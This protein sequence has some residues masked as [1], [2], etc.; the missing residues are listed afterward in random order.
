MVPAV[1]QLPDTATARPAGWGKSVT[2]V[3]KYLY[4]IVLYPKCL[5]IFCITSHIVSFHTNLLFL[6]D[7]INVFMQLYV[8]VFKTSSTLF[9]CK[10][11]SKIIPTYRSPLY[12]VNFIEYISITLPP[13]FAACAPGMYGPNCEAH[14]NCL[15]SAECDAA[16][17][18]C[19][20]AAGW[21]GYDCRERCLPDTYGPG[22][23]KSCLCKNNA[24]CDHVSGACLCREGWRG[25]MCERPCPE[26][27]F[28]GSGL[29]G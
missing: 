27:S 6:L 19:L 20:C 12:G 18:E 3:R 9:I 23:R 7:F 15:N 14:C 5:Y 26:V 10:Y 13:V 1:T 11:G 21:R 24:K 28:K 25:L 2:N 16:S 4:E 17:G 22:C 8:F 29:K